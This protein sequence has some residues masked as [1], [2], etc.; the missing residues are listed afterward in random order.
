M[1]T[2]DADVLTSRTLKKGPSSGEWSASLTRRRQARR[3]V[4]RRGEEGWEAEVMATA[5]VQAPWN[6]RAALA[7]VVLS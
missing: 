7:V 6:H 1:A 5:A 2:S 3:R 4:D